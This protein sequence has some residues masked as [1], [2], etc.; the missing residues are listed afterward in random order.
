MEV[1]KNGEEATNK[2]LKERLCD[3]LRVS[4]KEI[5]IELIEKIRDNDLFFFEGLVLDLLDKTGYSEAK[6]TNRCND[7]GIDGIINQDTLGTRTVYL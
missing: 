6:V 2:V 5:A 7:G 3:F 4:N 1:L